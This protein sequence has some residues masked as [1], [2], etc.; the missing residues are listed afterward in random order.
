M[1]FAGTRLFVASLWA[2][3]PCCQLKIKHLLQK[4]W[5]LLHVKILVFI[6]DTCISQ[7]RETPIVW[8]HKSGCVEPC[9]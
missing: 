1:V 9:C 6:F 5:F 2:K 3:V 7:S 4:H 8:L